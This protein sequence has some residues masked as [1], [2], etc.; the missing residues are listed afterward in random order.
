MRRLISR[1]ASLAA[2][3]TVAATVLSTAA[4]AHPGLP[5]HTHDG[6]GAAMVAAGAFAASLTVLALLRRARSA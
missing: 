6:G 3:A 5:G 2:L 4:L 1:T